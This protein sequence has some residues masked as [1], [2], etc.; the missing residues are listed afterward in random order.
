VKAL[1]FDNDFFKIITLKIT[2]LFNKNAALGSF[3]PISYCDVEEP[4]LPDRNW[5]K[6]KNMSCG[7]CG[8][9]IHLIF[10]EM[11]PKCFPAAIP[12]IKRKFL[13]HELV[14]RIVEVGN[15]VED[16]SIGDR[17]VMRIDWPSCYQMEM[18]PPCPQC[19]EGAYMLCENIGLKEPVELNIGGGFSP[20]MVM[21]KTQ[22]FKVPDNFTD[23]QALLIE[24]SASSLH[25]VLKRP[26]KPQENILV[27][28]A[29]AIGLLTV[30]M[31]KSLCKEARLH[32]LARHEFQARAAKKLGADHVWQNEENIYE[33]IAKKT[34]GRA[35]TGHFGN[36]IL[37]GG[38]DVIYDTVGNDKT[39]NNALRWTKGRGA[40]V[41][42][43]IN[44]MPGKI[45]Y[46]PI[47]NQEITVYG[48]NCHGTEKPG[49][50]SFEMAV[51]VL[52]KNEFP[53]TDILTHRFPMDEFKKAI[54]T[55]LSKK[56]TKAIKVVLDH[57]N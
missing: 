45:D 27:I 51:D 17:V 13:G 50:N 37:I 30:A 21:H 10:M 2:S 8:T 54:K 22:P 41:I 20:Y 52:S 34:G 43:G 31:A 16:F 18:D 49:A 26:P 36:K 5:V 6:V 9:D 33:Q 3:S 56:N 39:I 7:I 57:E 44:F 47:W 53:Y 25:G 23:D 38:Y 4:K 19:K 29:G 35:I 42:V 12:G 55:F 46:T 28:G 32:C 24:P 14:G 40:L 1:Y 15:N 48:I 11:D